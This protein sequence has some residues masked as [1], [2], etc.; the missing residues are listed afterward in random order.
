MT[1]YG[2]LSTLPAGYYVALALLTTSF[3]IAVRSPRHWGLLALHVVL[4]LVMLHATPA[5]LY[6]TLRYPW[7]W[8]HVGIIDYI[9]RHGSVNQNIG[10]LT[11]YQDWPAFFALGALIVQAGGFGS[12]LAFASWAPLFNNL[13]FAAAT[14]FIFR[15][16]THD[17]RLAWLAVWVFCVTSW[18]G[19][20]Y[21]SPQATNYFLYLI[22]LGVCLRWLGSREIPAAESVQRWVRSG[23]R[24]VQLRRLMVAGQ[25]EGRVRDLAPQ[26]PALVAIII[27]ITAVIVSGHQLTPFML[28]LSLSALVVFQVCAARGLPLLV[29]LMTAAWIIYMSVGF[30][31]GNLYWIVQSIGSLNIGGSTLS[32]LASASHDHAV[33]AQVTRL[34]TVLVGALAV[35]GV[36]RRVR[37]GHLDLAAV[38][39]AAVPVL[40]VWGNA[41]G[42]EML[43]RVYFFALPFLAFLIA[44][45]VFPSPRSGRTWMS[46]LLALALCAALLPLT[47]ISYYGSER[48]YRF[49]HDEVRSAQYLAAHAPPGSTLVGLTTAYPW[50]YRNY[51]YYSYV[52]LG[53]LPPNEQLRVLRSPVQQIVDQMGSGG[54]GHEYVVFSRAQDA[55]VEMTGALPPGSPRAL[56]DAIRASSRFR[57]VYRGPD[58]QVFELVGQGGRA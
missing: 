37:H 23:R 8:K 14:M 38:L 52:Q 1:D 55:E 17:R 21:F 32:N 30:L 28:I 47:L 29:G 6:G 24:A 3:C 5:I 48:M 10:Q 7:A 19:Q 18:V 41:Y 54:N 46:A 11:A 2:L 57:E 20:D 36:V 39:L 45:L 53:T 51:E 12:A 42:G 56:E 9:Q 22:V 16:L 58:A 49:S 13:L 50:G 43:F 34:L 35:A 15:S 33:V 26:A 25:P 40:M 44:G 27:T 31:K 4:L